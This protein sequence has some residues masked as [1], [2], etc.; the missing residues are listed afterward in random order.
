MEDVHAIIVNLVSNIFWLPIGVLLAAIGYFIQVRLPRRRLW[1]LTNPS[2]LVVCAAAS[3][4]TDTG[5]YNRPAT[6]IGQVRA[7]AIAVRSLGKAYSHSMDIKNIYLSSENLQDRLEEDVLLLGGPKTNQVTAHFLE[8]MNDIQPVMQFANPDRIVWRE[9]KVGDQ[10]I[11]A[12]ALEYS[13]EVVHR[14]VIKDYG[15]I[16]RVSSP[17][18]SQDRTVVLLS[19]GHTYGMVAAAKYFTEDMQRGFYWFRRLRKKNVVVVVGA[20]ILDGHPTK[21]KLEK[22]YTW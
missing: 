11:D 3:T 17:F 21:I 9:K 13:S 18:T 4:V 1:R 14:K 10:W 7:L 2:T 19:G 15:L 5:V 22:V 16:M 12:G 8:L 6:G 20:Q